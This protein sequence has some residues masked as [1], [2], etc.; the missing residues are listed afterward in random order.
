MSNLLHFLTELAINPQKQEA[1]IKAPDLVMDAVRLS[2][3][4]KTALKSRDR[5]RIAAPFADEFPEMSYAVTEPNPDPLPDPDPF[6]DPPPP[7]DSEPP[8]ELT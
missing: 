4:D 7:P 2:E 5:T 3:A 6:P 1:F 8:G